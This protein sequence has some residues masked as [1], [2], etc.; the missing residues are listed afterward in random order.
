MNECQISPCD[1]IKEVDMGLTETLKIYGSRIKI[2]NQ[3]HHH[4]HHHHHH[5]RKGGLGVL[6]PMSTKAKAA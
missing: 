5:V 6:P 4:H 1:Y 3:R 2:L